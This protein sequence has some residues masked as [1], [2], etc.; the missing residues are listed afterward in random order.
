M[1]ADTLER[2]AEEPPLPPALPVS[3]QRV[4]SAYPGLE[5][6]SLVSRYEGRRYVL[7]WETMPR[8]RDLPREAAPPP[9]PLRMY[10][11]PDAEESSATRVGS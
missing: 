4:E 8:N 11:L 5:V 9:T 2:V 7:R 10:E 1:R 6:H 3:L